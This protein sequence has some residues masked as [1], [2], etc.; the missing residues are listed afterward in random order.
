D[1]F[2]TIRATS[3]AVWALE[4]DISRIDPDTNTIDLTLKL[5]DPPSPSRS[6]DATTDRLMIATH[7]GGGAGTKLL[8]VDAVSGSVLRS[9]GVT[10]GSPSFGD[11]VAIASANDDETLI[12]LSLITDGGL[13][14]PPPSSLLLV[15]DGQVVSRTKVIEGASVWFIAANPD[16]SGWIGSNREL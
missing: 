10:P 3:G 15:R 7:G 8:I 11:H 13:L 12:T 2:L 6:F 1:G 14:R 9:D 5:P 4:S 16:G